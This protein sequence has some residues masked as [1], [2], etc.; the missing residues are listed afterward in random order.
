MLPFFFIF[1]SYCT[2]NLNICQVTHFVALF[3][4]RWLIS[5]PRAAFDPFVRLVAARLLKGSSLRPL[6]RTRGKSA[7]Y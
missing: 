6:V 5:L 1:S 2:T 3:S 4:T 7:A